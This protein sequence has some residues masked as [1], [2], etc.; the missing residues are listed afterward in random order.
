MRIERT[1][2]EGEP[3]HEH[4]SNA[5]FLFWLAGKADAVL[6]SYKN[7]LVLFEGRKGLD[8]LSGFL[9]SET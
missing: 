5:A 7:M 8:R 2:F 3:G 6:K 4:C 9:F 1:P